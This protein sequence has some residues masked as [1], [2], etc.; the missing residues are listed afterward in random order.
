MLHGSNVFH[1]GEPQEAR[2]VWTNPQTS[3]DTPNGV[4]VTENGATQVT[5]VLEPTGTAA[6]PTPSRPP[7]LL[8]IFGAL[9]NLWKMGSVG[10]ADSG[11]Q[12][13]VMRYTFA[14]VYDFI[15]YND[16]D[17][18]VML[19]PSQP[20]VAKTPILCASQTGTGIN[21]P[22]DNG[23]PLRRGFGDAPCGKCSTQFC[24][25]DLFSHAQ[26]CQVSR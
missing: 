4:Q 5:A 24:I 12:D 17:M 7:D 13:C 9:K 11:V 18:R 23:R 8:T 6:L 14:S 20:Q 10:G 2:L 22:N 19:F 26:A 15:F 21:D 3:R 16:G 1:H 25:N